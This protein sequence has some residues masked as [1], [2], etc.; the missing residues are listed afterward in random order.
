MWWIIIVIIAVIVIIAAASSSGS[1][2]QHGDYNNLFA[3]YSSSAHDAKKRSIYEDAEVREAGKEGEE[4]VANVLRGVCR[5]GDMYW[6]NVNIE[7]D[8][9]KSEIDH[10]I[11]TEYGLFAIES[12]NYSAKGEVYGEDGDHEWIMYKPE[13]GEKKPQTNPVKQAQRQAGILGKILKRYGAGVYVN[14]YAALVYDNY[15]GNSEK[16]LRNRR[17]ADRAIHTGYN[18]KPLPRDRYEKVA[19]VLTNNLGEREF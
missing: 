4:I 19:S 12:K 6:R 5:D 11:L 3:G 9:R 15:K 17:Q 16:V 13:Y 8:G 14:P 10:L 1:G 7:C 18:D 2:E